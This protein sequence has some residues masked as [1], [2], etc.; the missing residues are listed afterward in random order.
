MFWLKGN[1]ICS[2][3]D[4]EK[5]YVLHVTRKKRT[6]IYF[7]QVASFVLHKFYIM[8]LEQNICI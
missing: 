4:G 6:L 5:E 3:T 1:L 2:C 8:R 7:V